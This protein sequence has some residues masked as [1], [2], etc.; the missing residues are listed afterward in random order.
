MVLVGSQAGEPIRDQKRRLDAASLR[1]LV[2]NDSSGINAVVWEYNMAFED[3]GVHND[4]NEIKQKILDLYGR[5]L[6]ATLI[7]SPTSFFQWLNEKPLDERDL[8]ILVRQSVNDAK[9]LL[10]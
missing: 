3:A 4:G 2:S 5:K 10:K 9:E 1:C 6:R 7:L 8:T